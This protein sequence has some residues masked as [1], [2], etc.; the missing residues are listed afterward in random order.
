[1][2]KSVD[3]N[4]WTMTYTPGTKYKL[5]CLDNNFSE[6]E[7]S[8][9]VPCGGKVMT[10]DLYINVKAKKGE[11]VIARTL[12]SE[13]LTPIITKQT[14]PD[15]TYNY[16]RASISRDFYTQKLSEF[17]N[18]W[19]EN[20]PSGTITTKL[21]A[22]LKESKC[23]STT[24]PTGT[25]YTTIGG[26][27]GGYAQITE[28]YTYA[29][30]VQVTACPQQTLNNVIVNTGIGT[31]TYTPSSGYLYSSVSIKQINND[32]NVFGYKLP[33]TGTGSETGTSTLGKD[34]LLI[35]LSPN[36]TV[37][38]Y[39]STASWSDRVSTGTI[40]AGTLIY[41]DSSGFWVKQESG[42]DTGPVRLQF[43][44]SGISTS[45]LVVYTISSE[46]YRRLA[47]ILTS[48]AS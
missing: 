18:G 23:T 46:W 34:Q 36:M 12:E 35:C 37:W 33:Y 7:M 42:I 43:R 27:A 4:N 32:R 17:T 25:N 28:G 10:D 1:M 44:G 19:F 29:G 39:P 2:G 24:T 38:Y 3:K 9:K 31:D 45:S 26:Y 5:T 48:N 40:P 8:V 22:K 41:R 15:P 11:G 30:Y 6:Q 21:S 16:I 13:D 47:V 20:S 14:M